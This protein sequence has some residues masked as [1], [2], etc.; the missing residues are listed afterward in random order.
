MFKKRREQFLQVLGNAVA[1]FVSAP[2]AT[3]NGDVEYPYR[4]D[5]D[6][7]Y[8]TGF[9][10]PESVAVFAPSHPEAQFILFVRNRDRERE[11]W[12][13]RRAGVEGARERY[14]ADAAF[15]IDQLDQELPKYLETAEILHYRF[16]LNHS[17]NQ[18]VI[19]WLQHY[20]RARP[21]LGRGPFCVLDTGAILHEMRLR[22]SEEEIAILRQAARITSE[23]HVAGMR[24]ARPGVFEYQIEAE[25]DYHFR[26]SGA[27]GPG[28]PTIV[29]SGSNSTILH[30]IENDRQLCD[31]DV[32]LVDAGAECEF[33]T[34]DC[35]RTFPAGKRFT[36]PQRRLYDAVLAAQLHA[37]EMIRPGVPFDEINDRTI[38]LLTEAMVELRLLAGSVDE[39]IEKGEYK[40]FFP[41]RT[42]HWLGMDV[43]D[44]GPYR[45]TEG[46]RVL[47]PG[48][49]LTVEPGLY[50]AEKT[51]DVP[52]EFRGIGI[53]IEDDVLVTVE[54]REVLTSAPKQVDDL[55]RI[56]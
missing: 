19:G 5:S 45:S 25:I 35:T 10:E 1:L 34:A 12:T 46:S 21:R 22:K 50:I 13:G 39:L 11:I 2:I 54:G 55:Y 28:Y 15:P 26:K 37:I 44:A 18:K 48:M 20:Q 24:A 56:K 27:R 14:G 40:K 8:L 30:S 52:E 4:Q 38:R 42:S 16:G 49:V 43:H 17:F 32:V 31:G 47:E 41:H 51:E 6:F 33:L 7:Y 53:R 3:R 23:A 29:G 36:E 9:P